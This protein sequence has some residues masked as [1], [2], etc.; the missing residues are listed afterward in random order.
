MTRGR[1]LIAL[2]ALATAVM[3]P[4]IVLASD[5]CSE[6]HGLTTDETKGEGGSR[7]GHGFDK[8]DTLSV[9][10]HQSPNQMKMTV[11]L[12]EYADPDGPFE[13]VAKE[14]SDAFTY[15]VP[16]RTSDFIYLNFGGALPGT[17]VSWECKP[18]SSTER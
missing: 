9:S 16:K 8:G 7:T 10:I 6:F 18:A 11:N 17:F 1:M 3:A 5:G 4:S 2:C 15:T 12:L 14:T 13:E